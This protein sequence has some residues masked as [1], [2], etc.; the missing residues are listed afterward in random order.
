VKHRNQRVC[1]PAAQV[2][3][4]RTAVLAYAESSGLSI[5]QVALMCRLRPEMVYDF[6]GY[7]SKSIRVIQALTEHLP[8]NLSLDLRIR[9]LSP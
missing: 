9:R 8:L 5:R 3:E 6:I 2:E 7:R 4:V 1:L